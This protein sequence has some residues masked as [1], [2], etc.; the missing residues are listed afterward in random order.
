VF[1]ADE[2]LENFKIS[3][4]KALKD[5]EIFAEKVFPLNGSNYFS[6]LEQSQKSVKLY[7]CSNYKEKQDI[8][9]GGSL[10]T[11]VVYVKEHNALV[12]STND[13]HLNFYDIEDSKLVRRFVLEDAQVFLAVSDSKGIL[14][15][16]SISGIIYEWS[17][18][19]IFSEHKQVTL[20]PKE[21]YTEFLYR[22][23]KP[24][25]QADG[26]TYMLNV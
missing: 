7:D 15:S 13:K 21:L 26:L 14:F 23:H 25:R 1:A 20:S 9:C 18:T 3:P 11:N 8:K 24:I 12:M 22:G 5:V 4:A 16:G 19:K 2:S 17:L 6:V 10:I